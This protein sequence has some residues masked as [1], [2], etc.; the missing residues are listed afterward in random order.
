MNVGQDDNVVGSVLIIRDDY[1]IYYIVGFSLVPAPCC[2]HYFNVS[3][4]SRP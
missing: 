4:A 1:F 3:I 2:G